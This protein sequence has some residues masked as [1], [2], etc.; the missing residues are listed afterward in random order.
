MEAVVADLRLGQRQRRTLGVRRA[1]VHAH[2]LDLS[3]VTP[4]DLEVDTQ[5]CAWDLK[6]PL[7]LIQVMFEI[8]RM[9]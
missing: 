8:E 9:N 3:G 1:H 2:M 4:V 5:C 6:P 7:F